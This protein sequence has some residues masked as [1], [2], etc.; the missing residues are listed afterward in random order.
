MQPA[1]AHGL[2]IF[3]PF[4]SYY[5]FSCLEMIASI[6]LSPYYHVVIGWAISHH[7][8][9]II[10]GIILQL[11]VHKCPLPGGSFEF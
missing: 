5:F 6:L 3:P 9:G 10:L 11:V 2:T 7:P 8:I 4:Y 1:T